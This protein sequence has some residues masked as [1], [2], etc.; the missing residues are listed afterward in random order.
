MAEKPLETE[1]EEQRPAQSKGANAPEASESPAP[2][3]GT[4]DEMSNLLSKL[5]TLTAFFA[6]GEKPTGSRDPFALRRAAL[7]VIRIV[8]GSELRIPLRD[9]ALR[10]DEGLLLTFSLPPGCYATVVLR[11]LSKPEADPHPM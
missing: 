7:G 5:D 2:E 9:V 11:E 1:T 8:L 6:I 4:G 10:Y 3:K